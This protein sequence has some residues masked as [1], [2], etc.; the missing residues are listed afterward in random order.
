MVQ[1]AGQYATFAASACEEEP[2]YSNPAPQR[3]KPPAY[4]RSKINFAII[5]CKQT[6]WVGFGLIIQDWEG[7]VLA[8]MEDRFNSHSHPTFNQARGLLKVLNFCLEAD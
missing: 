7:F 6:S 3:W 1:E 5:P 4:G 8:T 2:I